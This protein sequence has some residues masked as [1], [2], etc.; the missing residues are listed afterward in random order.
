MSG[1]SGKNVLPAWFTE[2]VLRPFRAGITHAF[3]LHGDI[4]C[5]VA[6]PDRQ[7]EPERPYIPLNILWQKLFDRGSMVIFYN[8]ASGPTFLTP[9]ME[10]RFKQIAGLESGDST[11]SNPVAAA[12]A[13]LAAKRN[14]P[15]EPDAC[16]PLI[17]KVLVQLQNVAVIINSL[18]FIAPGGAA[19]NL[20]PANERTN[21][22][23][24]RNWG[25]DEQIK[26][27][28]NLIIMLTDQAE[29]VS[30][31]LRQS[32]SRIR[33]IFIPKPGKEDRLQY[34]E[35]LTLG[36]PECQELKAELALTQEKLKQRKLKADQK[37]E[38]SERIKELE[39][40]LEIFEDLKLFP[41]PA[42]FP[43]KAFAV[44]TQG[45]SLRQILDIFM[46]SQLSGEEVSLPYV[47]ARK[48]TILNEEYGDV[49]EIVEP[50]L[51]LEN[52]GGLWHVKE[53][54]QSVLNAMK[55]GEI[56][57]VPMGITLMGPPGTGKTALV[58][59]L[60]KEAGYLFVKTKNIRSMWLGES[61]ARQA[62]LIN[63]LRSLAPVI[64]MNDEADLNDADRNA[65][66]G[67]SGV[68]ERLMKMWMEF[69]SDPRIM[70]KIVVVSCTNRP[71]RMDA[72]LLRSGRSDERILLPMPAQEER[73]A[74]WQVMFNR[75]QLPSSIKDFSEAA[76]ITDG[77]SGADIEKIAKSAYRFAFEQ[78]KSEIDDAIL[79]ETIGD[80]I[81]GSSQ[82]EIDFMTIMAVMCCSSKK[83]LPKNIS[84]L[85]AGI[86]KRNLVPN[87]ADYL[88]QARARGI[89]NGESDD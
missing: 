79:E 68:S 28:N 27:K 15:R 81:P 75:Y 58:E 73:A 6:N 25:E 51:G 20:I 17:E 39:E 54:F 34:I 55:I 64:V 50:E 26:D 84:E 43:L 22:E 1:N 41:L 61:E 33:T 32:D 46:N 30:P 7:E 89:I 65:P 37:E 88:D 29:K 66:K 40:K 74:I 47:K 62:R 23:R 4:N 13:S 56:R 18:H 8:I 63:G 59:A 3:I 16:L 57:L 36:P 44:A 19:G 83:L 82:P 86:K 11:D 78:G 10:K 21:I 53:Y 87:L 85:I 60:A 9:E 76:R 71:D 31:E 12:K 69:L 48:I 80:F 70:G 45:L 14:I 77:L 35:T 2:E 5:L 38:L 42:A 49:M 52:I 72:A 67:D 24:L